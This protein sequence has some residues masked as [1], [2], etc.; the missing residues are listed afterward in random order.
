MNCRDC[1]A[2][3][4]HDGSIESG[5]VEISGQFDYER[6]EG[7]CATDCHQ[8]DTSDYWGCET[9][10][11]YPPDTGVHTSHAQPSGKYWDIADR[12]AEAGDGPVV[13]CIECHADHTH[14]ARATDPQAQV[15]SAH[16]SLREG[17]FV[18]NTERCNTACHDAF[19]W[20]ETCDTC[21]TAPPDSGDHV[22]HMDEDDIT[23][24]TCHTTS[25]HDITDATPAGDYTGGVVD[26]TS[27]D[28]MTGDCSTT[29]HVDDSGRREVK[30]WDC[31]SCHDLPPTTG[32][33][34]VHVEYDISCSVCHADHEHGGTAA[35]L[36]LDLS[37]ASIE[38]SSRGSY[39]EGTQTCSNIGCHR[40]IGWM[41]AFGER[42]L[43]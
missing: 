11:D 22:V 3:N 24:G 2:G 12:V 41:A 30:S 13:G 20:Q 26:I 5:V 34:S 17:A 9:C 27:M 19:S 18:A 15:L 33:H 28:T 35:S 21:H 16:V 6:T 42:E 10:H 4:D 8:T 29:C 39:A 1:H 31:A 37:G 7:T 23:C 32:A 25:R 40:D 36:P 43:R 14:S 38:F